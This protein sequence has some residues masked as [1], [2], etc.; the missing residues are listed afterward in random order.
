MAT[1][2]ELEQAF[3]L[4]ETALNG[5]HPR[6]MV[7]STSLHSRKGDLQRLKRFLLAMMDRE[8]KTE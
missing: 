6:T 1:K 4:I 3:S 7:E 5:V 2:A 8:A